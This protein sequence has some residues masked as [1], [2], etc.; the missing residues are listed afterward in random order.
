ME[1]L[2]HSKKVKSYN[3]TEMLGKIRKS[4]FCGAYSMKQ[5]L[6]GKSEVR[7]LKRCFDVLNLHPSI[8]VTISSM[9][10]F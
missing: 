2:H 1:E 7:F 6:I 5:K 3:T 8:Y 10:S 4:D 9:F